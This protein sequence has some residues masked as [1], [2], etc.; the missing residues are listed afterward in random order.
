MFGVLLHQ[1]LYYLNGDIEGKS[2]ENIGRRCI[3]ARSIE[4]HGAGMTP[5]ESLSVLSRPVEG[6]AQQSKEAERLM[7]CLRDTKQ[8]IINV[9]D[10][11]EYE[12]LLKRY[13]VS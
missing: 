10:T 1:T 2:C 13:K 5:S 3:F 6:G 9:S 4:N 8:L 7:A 11:F 12:E